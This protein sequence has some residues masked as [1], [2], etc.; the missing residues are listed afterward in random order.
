[1]ILKPHSIKLTVVFGLLLVLVFSFSTA[2][3]YSFSVSEKEL[4]QE[5]EI[6][7]N[8]LTEKIANAIADPIYY[9]SPNNGGLVLSL[10]K[11]DPRIASL[12]I[13]DV[14][15][16]MEFINIY[17]PERA[18]GGLF[19]SKKNIRKKGEIIGEIK[20]VF[21]DS[22]LRKQIQA[23]RD[24]IIKVFAFTFIVIT[25]IMFP[26]LHFIIFK[27]LNRLITQAESFQNNELEEQYI[28]KENSEISIVGQ[29][30]E[31]ARMAILKLISELK[32]SNKQLEKIAI[33]DNLTGLF[34]RHK[35]DEILENEKNRFLRY[36]NQFC[37][38]L[39]DID[40]FKQVNDTYGHQIGDEILTAF[41]KILVKNTRQSDVVARWGGEEFLIVCPES[42]IEETFQLAE[43]LRITIQQFKFPVA[44]TQTASFGITDFKKADRVS[45]LVSRADQALYKAK[46]DGR[47]KV[48]KLS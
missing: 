20:I 28:W 17:I 48:I 26:L 41:A 38:I 47:N 35:L 19:E 29:S 2:A 43:K 14:F 34:N 45:D 13:Y 46:E 44:R 27:P 16:E 31:S 12:D 6:E 36:G 15:N 22:R 25:A 8:D 37:I 21:N 4:Y 7:R 10:V 42:N 33:I 30:F 5:F 11:Q 32:A 18:V 24:L 9:L 39:L 23:K 1:L 3:W 40:H